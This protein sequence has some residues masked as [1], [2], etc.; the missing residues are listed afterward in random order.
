MSTTKKQA[1]LEEVDLTK[2]VELLSKLCIVDDE[3]SKIDRELNNK[4][5]KSLNKGQKEFYLR[6]KMKAIKEEL[7]QLS[8]RESE[9]ESFKKR[10]NENPYPKYIK[11]R[12]LSELAKIEST[13][14]QEAA[15][16]LS[17]VQW[18]LDLPWWQMTKDSIDLSKVIKT[19]DESHYGLEKVK[20][21]I[22]EYL[23]IKMRSPNSKAPIICL[24]GP[25][26]VGKSTLA[27][28][29][30]KSL[31]KTF[32]KAAL[33]GVRDEAEIRGHRRTYLGSMPGRI[34]K[35]MKKAG[36]INPLF[37]LDEVDKMTS[38]MRGDPS[39]ALLEV[40]DTE[41]NSRFSDNYIEEDYD[42]SKV[43]FVATANYP[44]QI[45]A[46]LYD[47]LEIIELTSYTEKE[48]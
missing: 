3:M 42:L 10:V 41:Q 20:Q 25:P 12:V 45:P 5:A 33:G 7:G 24:V 30:A 17:Y 18:L 35:A 28:S 14:P 37:L 19:L 48:N 22:I 11:D 15:L 46:P 2:R 21:R 31:N 23:A 34:I 9:V 4:V 47:R 26:G 29:I 32:V 43:M 13:H 44:D 16:N 27:Y 40:L 6:E 39:S 36:V 8:S 1:I 38:D